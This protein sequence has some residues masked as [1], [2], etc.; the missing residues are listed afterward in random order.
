MSM[1]KT[2]KITKEI[3]EN[4]DFRIYSKPSH[5]VRE[6]WDFF[7]K[8]FESNN[9]SNGKIFENLIVYILAYEGIEHIYEQAEVVFVPNAIFDILLYHP[10][11]THTLSLK[12]TL[13]E[14]WKQAD[15][16]AYAI[17]NVLKESKSYVITLSTSEVKARRKKY[18]KGEDFYNGLDGFILADSKE[19]DDLI[20]KLKTISFLPS[21]K[22]SIIKKDDNYSNI[23][24]LNSKF[25]IE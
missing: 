10:K 11:N 5:F 19:F 20:T 18:E 3:I 1:S 4:Y 21:E 22:I 7:E 25:G 6:S 15:L 23:E 14:R 17:K 9:S 8:N 12:T 13:R 2:E 24:M 16:E